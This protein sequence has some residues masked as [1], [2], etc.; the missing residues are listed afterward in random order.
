MSTTN[1]RTQVLPDPSSPADEITRFA[2]EQAVRAPSVHNT[3]PWWFY[4]ADREIG[5]HADDERQL[6]VADPEGRE[7]LISCGAALFTI[8]VALR[9]AGLVPL[10]RVLPEPDLPTLV[11]KVSWTEAAPPAEIERVLFAAVSQRRTHR[12]AFEAD[13]A[14]FG[15]HDRAG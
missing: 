6:H 11:A 5:I 15:H 4:G 1:P 7:M 13:A 14:A 12:G 10:V 3:Q 9:N 8:R 2:I